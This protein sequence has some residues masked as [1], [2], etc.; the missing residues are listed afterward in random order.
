MSSQIALTTVCLPLAS[1]ECNTF[2]NGVRIG[3]QVYSKSR[4]PPLLCG[5]RVY[6]KHTRKC[7]QEEDRDQAILL[8]EEVRRSFENA[9][10]THFESLSNDRANKET[11]IKKYLVY[12]E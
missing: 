8:R 12:Y 1:P 6:K 9:K 2:L 3:K 10:Q 5:K 7:S 11:G 4:D